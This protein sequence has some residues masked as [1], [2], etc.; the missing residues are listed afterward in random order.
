VARLLG[1]VDKIDIV[2]AVDNSDPALR[3][4]DP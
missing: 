3:E 2:L 4:G 1:T